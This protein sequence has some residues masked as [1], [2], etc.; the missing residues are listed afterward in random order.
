[1]L[2]AKYTIN[3]VAKESVMVNNTNQN[4]R[5]S[6]VKYTEMLKISSAIF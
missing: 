5:I 2:I 6:I 1:M 3:T 4:Q